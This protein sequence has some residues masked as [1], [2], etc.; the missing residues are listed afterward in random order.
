MCHYDTIGKNP[1]SFMPIYKKLG[2]EF[3]ALFKIKAPKEMAH[4]KSRLEYRK[5]KNA[6]LFLKHTAM[7]K[8]RARTV[9]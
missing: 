8:T 3:C 6:Q 2:N 7:Q 4:A 9:P 1:F 5:Q